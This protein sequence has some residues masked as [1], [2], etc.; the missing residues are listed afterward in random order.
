MSFEE[1]DLI[2][3]AEVPKHLIDAKK[4]ILFGCEVGGRFSDSNKLTKENLIESSNMKYWRF[5]SQ[6][7]DSDIIIPLTER[8]QS[9]I[10]AYGMPKTDYKKTDDV[11]LN[12][13]IKKVCEI[14]GIDELI[15]ARKSKS[16][17]VTDKNNKEKSVRRTI[18]DYYPKYEV[19]TTHSFRRSFCTNYYNILSLYQ[20]RQVSGHASDAQLMEYINQGKDKND[21]VESMIEKMNNNTSSIQNNKMKV[22]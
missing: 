9:Y 16:V 18:S 12:R 22:V 7:T 21:I 17:I 19:I 1:L 4:A 10:D 20:I 3:K 15:K 13:D 11:I 5:R 2:H 14:A 8:I 6:K